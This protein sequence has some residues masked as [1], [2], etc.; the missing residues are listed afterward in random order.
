MQCYGSLRFVV[1]IYR[2]MNLGGKA[3]G[4]MSTGRIEFE[5]GASVKKVS[6]GK[7]SFQLESTGGGAEVQVNEGLEIV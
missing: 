7:R 2:D 5:F 4:M 6:D 1:Y 3:K